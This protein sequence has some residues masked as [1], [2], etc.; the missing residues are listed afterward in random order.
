MKTE[1][2]LALEQLEKEKGL[3][4]NMLF[5]VIEDAVVK[6]YKNNFGANHNVEVELNRNT[7][8]INAYSVRVVTDEIT[9]EDNQISLED[10][11][12]NRSKL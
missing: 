11:K 2:L 3:E 1:L 7:G 8:E 10:A 4:I 9:D 5:D 12:K 6:A